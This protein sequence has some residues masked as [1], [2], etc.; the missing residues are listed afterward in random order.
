M[1][2]ILGFELIYCLYNFKINTMII[3]ILNSLDVDILVLI[4][5]L[6][7]IKKSNYNFN[8]GIY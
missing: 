3:C 4:I 2:D 5:Y 7:F 6:N 8:C 1:F